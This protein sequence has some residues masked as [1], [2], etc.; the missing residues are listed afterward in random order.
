MRVC[1]L[2]QF[3]VVPPVLRVN[4]NPEDVKERKDEQK[5]EEKWNGMLWSQ[6]KYPN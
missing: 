6:R 1:V 2:T 3:S 5:W 4:P